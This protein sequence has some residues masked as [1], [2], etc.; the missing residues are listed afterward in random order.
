MIT[1]RPGTRSLS[2]VQARAHHL[3]R[4]FR[5][6]VRQAEL[7]DSPHVRERHLELAGR[8]ERDLLELRDELA[9]EAEFFANAGAEHRFQHTSRELTAVMRVIRGEDGP[10]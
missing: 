2:P 3:A 4:A 1:M 8:A 7:S 5:H 6:N 9:R 10:R